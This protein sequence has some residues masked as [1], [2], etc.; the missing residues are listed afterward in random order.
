MGKPRQKAEPACEAGAP[1]S[2]AGSAFWR[3][4][5]I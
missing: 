5:P 2:Q 3:G 1:A 4:L